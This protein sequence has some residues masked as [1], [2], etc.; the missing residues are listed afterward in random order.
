[1]ECLPLS[2][3]RKEGKDFGQ[4]TYGFKQGA[5]GNT[6][7][8]H[9]GNLMRTHWEL[10]RNMTNEKRKKIPPPLFP[11]PHPKLKRKKK[12]SYFECMLSLL[13]IGCMKFLFPKLFITILAWANTPIINWG[14]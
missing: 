2:A 5:I 9:I 11:P 13:P 10:E 6:L 14:C 1:M 12:S 4:K 7:G 3:H 8:E